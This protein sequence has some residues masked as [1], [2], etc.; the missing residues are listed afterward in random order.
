MDNLNVS[1]AHFNGFLLLN[2]SCSSFL[3]FNWT[4]LSLFVCCVWWIEGFT[5]GS[6]QCSNWGIH[7]EIMAA[8]MGTELISKLSLTPRETH[9]TRVAS[10]FRHVS[11]NTVW[12]L[13]RS[14]TVSCRG[15]HTESNRRGTVEQ[16]F[17]TRIGL[18]LSSR[19]RE[20]GQLVSVGQF[21]LTQLLCTLEWKLIYTGSP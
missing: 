19:Q 15:L 4:E 14:V 13:Q 2:L 10:H 5:V 3:G 17:Y 16:N 8:L 9:W 6:G 11:S 7:K 18:F 1:K 21:F 20:T 12:T